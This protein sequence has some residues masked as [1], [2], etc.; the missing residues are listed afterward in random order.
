MGDIKEKGKEVDRRRMWME[1]RLSP[2][3]MLSK[4]I[5]GQTSPTFVAVVCPHFGLL[6][7]NQ[8]SLM[9]SSGVM[10]ERVS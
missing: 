1:K 8:E 6:E 2:F 4:C 10:E 9:T 3:K 5:C 7:V